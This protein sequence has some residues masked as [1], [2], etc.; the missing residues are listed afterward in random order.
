[1]SKGDAKAAV[2][3]AVA[4]C[5]GVAGD[6]TRTE[7]MRWFCGYLLKNNI[8]QVDAV[9]GKHGGAYPVAGHAEKLIVIGDPVDDVQL[10][11]L[12]FQAQMGSV[13]E[14]AGDLAVGFKIL[15]PGC[16]AQD[17]SVPVLV[18]R[19]YDPD[20]PGDAEAAQQ[21]ARRMQRAVTAHAPF[22]TAVEAAIRSEADGPLAFLPTLETTSSHPRAA[23]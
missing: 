14:G 8:A 20:I 17:L 7:G 13:E 1:M 18:V 12:A 4:E 10:R 15:G 23:T 2:R 19:D 6:D 9:L 5:A 22:P 21:A 3:A 11:N 16:A